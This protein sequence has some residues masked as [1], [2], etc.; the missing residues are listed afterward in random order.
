MLNNH[1]VLIECCV[2]GSIVSP[3]FLFGLTV[4]LEGRDELAQNVTSS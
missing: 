4:G 2:H 1:F 3:S